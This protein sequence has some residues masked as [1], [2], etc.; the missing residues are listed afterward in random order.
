MNNNLKLPVAVIQNG[1]VIDHIPQ[2]KALSLISLLKLSHQALIL[3]TF[4]PSKKMGYKDLLKIPN[5]FLS[6]TLENSIALF[7][8]K[9]TINVIENSQITKKTAPLLPKKIEGFFTCLNSRCIT[10]AE[11]HLSC[12]DILS[13]KKQIYLQCHYCGIKFLKNEV[14]SHKL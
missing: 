6:K 3:A 13:S 1:L 12:F 9:A 7:A 8:P 11:K 5:I 4:L 2:G 14:T 10:H